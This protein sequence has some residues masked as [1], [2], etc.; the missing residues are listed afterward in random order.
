MKRS[1]EIAKF[2]HNASADIGDVMITV[3]FSARAEMVETPSAAMA[4][5]AV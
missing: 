1:A 3:E 5:S 2:F 4:A